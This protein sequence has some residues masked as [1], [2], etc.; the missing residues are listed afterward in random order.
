[1]RSGGPRRYEW[2]RADVGKAKGGCAGPWV[3]PCSA[4][5]QLGVACGAVAALPTPTRDPMA[6]KSC[7]LGAIF[8]AEPL[9]A[10]QDCDEG[11]Q[12]ALGFRSG[13]KGGMDHYHY[14]QAAAGPRRPEHS[15]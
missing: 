8:C 14:Q 9:T 13:S 5:R 6:S 3:G 10:I 2:E 11:K 4:G 1:M 15:Q 7:R 12:K